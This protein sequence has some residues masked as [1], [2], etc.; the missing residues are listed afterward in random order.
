MHNG[1]EIKEFNGRGYKGVHVFESWRIAFL[2]QDDEY[3]HNT[4][5]ERH[6]KTDEVFVLLKGAATLYI[7][8]EREPVEMSVNKIYNVTAGTWHNIVCD[9]EASVLVVENDATDKTNTEYHY[10]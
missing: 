9:E 5:I 10:L 7:G 3:T 2:T 6:M 8:M 4:Y 1:L